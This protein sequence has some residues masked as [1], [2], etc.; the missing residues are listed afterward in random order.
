MPWRILPSRVC[1]DTANSLVLEEDPIALLEAVIDRIAVVHVFDIRTPGE[2]ETV[3]VGT[4]ASPIKQVLSILKRSGFDGW[5]SIEEAS[6]TGEEGFEKG[7]SR[8]SVAHGRRHENTSMNVICVCLDTF[9]ADI[10]GPG[11]KFSHIQTPNLDAFAAESIRFTRAFG[12]GQP[13]LQIR[14]GL[15]TGMRSFPW[16]FNFEPAGTLAS[17]SWLAQNPARAG[18]DRGSACWKEVT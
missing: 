14:R 1:F 9:R 11:K 15:F 5:L 12:E 3:L 16:R 18:Y 2:F 10:I 8:S 17:C 13:T 6:R 7:W 4:G